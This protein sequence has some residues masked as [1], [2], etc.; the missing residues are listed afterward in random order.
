MFIADCR[1]C[2]C[3]QRR[4]STLL[5]MSPRDCVPY[6]SYSLGMEAIR[7]TAS[8]LKSLM[9]RR[10]VMLPA[11]CLESF[12]ITAIVHILMRY[13]IKPDYPAAASGII[14]SCSGPSGQC[15]HQIWV[16]LACAPSLLLFT[17]IWSCTGVGSKR[18]V[19]FVSVIDRRAC[20]GSTS[21]CP[22]FPVSQVFS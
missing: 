20:V 10:Y 1:F 14:L 9:Q 3:S 13:F 18:K 8:T 15:G 17:T 19:C 7:L 12:C 16:I 5:L 2:R 22:C 21:N 6:S 4:A 11:A